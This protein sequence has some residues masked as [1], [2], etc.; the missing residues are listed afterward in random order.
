M[1]ALALHAQTRWR[2]QQYGYSRGQIADLAAQFQ[3]ANSAG[4]EQAFLAFCLARQPPAPLPPP[5]AAT[6]QPLSPALQLWLQQLGLPEVFIGQC[7]A[8]FVANPK[9]TGPEQDKAFLKHCLMA[10]R[11][12]PLRQGREATV[13]VKAWRPLPEDWRALLAQ[14]L[15]E[16]WLEVALRE[17]V[18]YWCESGLARPLWSRKFYWWSQRQWAKGAWAW[19]Q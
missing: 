13:M 8:S 7:Q 6:P 14:G 17:F 3:R 12:S 15:K 11:L 5:A 4:T 16:A 1:S 18:L 19:L 9:N 10:W 2:L